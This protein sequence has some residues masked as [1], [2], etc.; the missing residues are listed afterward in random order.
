MD[1]KYD[2]MIVVNVVG[3]LCFSIEF[4]DYFLGEVYMR[5]SKFFEV[6]YWYMELLRFKIDYI[7]VYFIYGKLLVLIVSNY[8]FYFLEI[9]FFYVD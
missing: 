3:K 2:D 4:C 1:Y 5:L 8:F 9:G 7:F 6:E